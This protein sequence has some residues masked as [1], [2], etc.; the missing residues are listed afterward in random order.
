MNIPDKMKHFFLISAL[1]L[2]SCIVYSQTAGTLDSTFGV[3]G[4]VMTNVSPL[5][6]SDN[7]EDLLLQ[8]DGKLIAVGWFH[9]T[10]A[11]TNYSDLALIRYNTDGSIDSTFGTNGKAIYNLASAGWNGDFIRSAVLQSDGKILC[12]G[13][14]QQAA[15][16]TQIV[17]SRFLSNGIMDSTFG[18]NGISELDL[19]ASTDEGMSIV[20]QTDGKI[21]VGAVSNPSVVVRYKSNGIIDSTYGNN[22]IIYLNQTARDISL[23]LDGKILVAGEYSTSLPTWHYFAV[24]RVDSTGV[25]DSTFGTNG[26]SYFDHS[27]VAGPTFWSNWVNT[28]DVQSDGK[29]IIAGGCDDN[30]SAIDTRFAIGRLNSDGVLDSTFGAFGRVVIDFLGDFERIH[31]MVIQPDGKMVFVGEA[32][33]SEFA[34]VRIDVNGNL[35]NT[36]NGTGKLEIDFAGGWDYGYACVLQS[37]GKLVVDGSATNSSGNYD[38]SLVRLLNDLNLGVIDLDNDFSTTLFYPNPVEQKSVLKY[39]LKDDETISINLVDIQGKKI[40]TFIDNQKQLKGEHL[41][42]LEFSNELSKGVYFITIASKTSS[43]NVKIIKQ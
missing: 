16:N 33:N 31:D 7:L 10:T 32:N 25:V 11:M 13:S 24:T 29:I 43:V 5:S 27:I 38:F 21:L 34:I 19:T 41:E 28:I 4:K 9:T 23:L 37:D 20:V 6:T 15:T 30:A 14:T 35:D 3:F 26:L 12:T 36:F 22:G 17:L 39:S 2:F 1:S 42:F 40:Q 18:S 8:P